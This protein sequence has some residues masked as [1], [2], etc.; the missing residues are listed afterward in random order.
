MISP[1]FSLILIPSC[2][3]L[4]HLGGQ[5][6]VIPNP[7]IVCRVFGI[8]VIFGLISYII[9]LPL[10]SI[11]CL[12]AIAMAGMALWAVPGWASGFCCIPPYNDHRQDTI[13]SNLVDKLMGVNRLVTLTPAKCHT[14]GMLYFTLRGLY[15]YPLF[16]GLGYFLTPWAYPIGLL[17]ALQG[18]IYGN[19]KTVYNAEFVMGALI[20]MMLSGAL[21][22]GVLHG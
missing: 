12:T 10:Y 4:S 2:S 9:G 19:C 16:A 17:S 5:S 15:L 6:T 18:L 3:F 22:L 13:L 14:W 8:G 7:R 1:F 20:G 21:I 11:S